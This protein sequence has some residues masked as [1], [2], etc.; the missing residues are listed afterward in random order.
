VTGWCFSELAVGHAPAQGVDH[1]A[2]VSV[3]VRINA[4]RQLRIPGRLG[5]CCHRRPLVSIVAARGQSPACEG[6]WQQA[7]MNSQPPVR[8]CASNTT[9]SGRRVHL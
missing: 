3:G 9:E 7:P 8:P 6:L 2:V 1:G 4:G 5:S